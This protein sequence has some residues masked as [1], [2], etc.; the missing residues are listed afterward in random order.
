M[1]GWDDP[2]MPTISGIRRRGVPPEAVRLFCER[3]GISKSDSNIDYADLENC[4][5]EV[6]DEKS[7]RAFAVVNPLKVTIRNWAGE[8]HL[9][10][11]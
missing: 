6:M 3:I 1:N 11:I 10:Q 9:N 8:F 4:V 5:R 7:L 2:R